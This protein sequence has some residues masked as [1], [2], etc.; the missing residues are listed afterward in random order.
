M[1]RLPACA[2]LLLLSTSGAFAQSITVSLRGAS[3]AQ[4]ATLDA[5]RIYGEAAP[6][7]RTIGVPSTQELAL[8]AGTWEIRVDAESLWSAPAYV[9]EGETAHIDLWP[10]AQLRATAT[11]TELK[12]LRVRFTA[13][14]HDAPSG[15]A[16]CRSDGDSWRCAIPAAGRYDLTLI[17]RGFAPEYRWATD[18]N[19][20]AVD[21]GAIHFTKGA[22][23]TGRVA[24]ARGARLDVAGTDVS[25]S[26]ASGGTARTAQA[27]AR[28]F[29][30]FRGV[31]AGEYVVRASKKGLTSRSAS[32]TIIEQTAADLTAPLLLDRAKRVDVTLLPMLDSAH[33]P[34]RV[35]LFAVDGTR[36]E[37]LTE[38]A[39]EGD[40]RWSHPAVIA[41][42]YRLEVHTSSGALWATQ[43]L[44]IADDDV[45]VPI[46]V[47]PSEI[48]GTLMLG[49]RALAAKLSFGGEGGVELQSNAN[50]EFRGFVPPPATDDTWTVLI[51]SEAPDIRRIVR[52]K[53]LDIVL[54]STT[55]IGRVRNEDGSAEPNAILA[56]RARSGNATV[57]QA[58]AGSDG[59]FQIAGFEPGEYDVSAESFQHSSDVL[60]VTLKSDPDPAELDIIVRPEVK[61]RGRVVVGDAPIVGARIVGFPRD[62]GTAF[63]PETTSNGDGRFELVL[64]PKTSLYD[65]LAVHPAFDVISARLTPQRE[66]LLVIT[67]QQSGGTLI[68]E[69]PAAAIVRLVHD[70]ADLPMRWA[71]QN[72]G[73]SAS[74]DAK[75][76]HIEMKRL[77]AGH[78]SACV[79]DRCV[80]GFVP[81]FGTITLSI[82]D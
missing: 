11:A 18:V 53:T 2:A 3:A 76:Q 26:P 33:A 9:R 45:S 54:P 8:G 20:A 61:I 29:F 50:G 75:R 1:R 80:A 17:A 74:E 63:L 21:L 59:R 31:A 5:R 19:A 62:S 25:V 4:T 44:T 51:E 82:A 55:L 60:H 81:P 7:Q 48:K 27:N 22:S 28:G 24:P 58:F 77:E 41:G 38:S 72:S 66:K 42:D 56:I 13:I 65:I 71:A 34:W 73:G 79:R 68:V 49:E 39:A 14:D 69:A 37:L 30:Q 40:G 70:G 36:V 64:P 6:Q 23:L 47:V 78:Y 15:E 43:S 67:T 16:V 10:V 32:V 57:E 52:T 46:A 35:A 12:S